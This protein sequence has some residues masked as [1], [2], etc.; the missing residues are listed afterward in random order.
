[1]RPHHCHQCSGG[2]GATGRAVWLD[3]GSQKPYSYESIL[4]TR[5]DLATNYFYTSKSW[6]G[7]TS[8]ATG[9][10]TP[11]AAGTPG[12]ITLSGLEKYL[13]DR[14]LAERIQIEA[15]GYTPLAGFGVR[16]TQN[17]KTTPALSDP[18]FQDQITVTSIG[19]GKQDPEKL[20]SFMM[21]SLLR[22]ALVFGGFYPPNPDKP[23]MPGGGHALLA[24]GLTL[25][26]RNANGNFD[27]GE[28][29]TLTFLDPLNPAT[30]YSPALG[31]TIETLSAFNSIAPVSGKA[32]F[33]T[34]P[35]SINTENPGYDFAAQGTP[36][37]LLSI[38]YDQGSLAINN[39]L[40]DFV[41]P[42][43]L[44]VTGGDT[45]N[46][47][48][49][50]QL[51]S[52]P[53]QM[54]VATAM[55]LHAKRL[56]FN[57]DN[58]ISS[59]PANTPALVNLKS[60]LGQADTISGFYYTNEESAFDNH[61]R[62]YSVIDASG[63]IKDPI[64]GDLLSPSDD[65]YIAVAK[66]LSDQ[67]AASMMTFDR[68]SDNQAQLHQFSLELNGL[69]GSYLAP[70]VTTSEQ[71]TWVPF[72]QANNDGEQHFITTGIGGWRMEDLNGLGDR[73]YNDL[74]AQLI[75]TDVS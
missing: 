69:K 68:A 28:S 38:D 41:P 56:P 39:N 73:D 75:I 13:Q 32:N 54:N 53:T 64:S 18:P 26:D 48:V 24:T 59:N 19:F 42:G 35:I 4:Q 40:P 5:N 70:I 71:Y 31:S 43:P 50:D 6:A 57:L 45:S 49:R 66:S 16:N 67:L 1:M 15:I 21:I 9:E 62:F 58:T 72:S 74:H 2:V 3:V 37:N 20:F 36:F 51:G 47:R 44:I 27:S 11:T 55:S 17:G 8:I 23:G 61:I 12:A 10:P 29:A 46:G 30:D 60:L 7:A 52:N 25:N 22:G 63:V 14:K 34:A 65:N 33:I